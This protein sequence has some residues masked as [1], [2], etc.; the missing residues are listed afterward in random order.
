VRRS[1]GIVLFADVGELGFVGP[2]QVFATVRRLEPDACRVFTVSESGGE[3]RCQGS[4]RVVAD[5]AFATAPRMDVLIVPGGNPSFAPLEYGPLIAYIRQAGAQADLVV[6]V[7]GGTP[8]L[9]Q[10]GF[11]QNSEHEVDAP[12]WI[13]SGAVIRAATGMAGIDVALYLVRRL[14]GERLAQ[15]VEIELD[16]RGQT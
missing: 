8:L 6:S 10:A 9:E 2:W 3:I 14:W 15:L 4:L 5:Y 12:R 1:I 13:D 16:Y 7:C 11:L